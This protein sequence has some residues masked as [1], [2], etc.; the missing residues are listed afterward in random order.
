MSGTSWLDDYW[1]ERQK[2]QER[3]E[4]QKR[5]RLQRGN[6]PRTVR[7]AITA[8]AYGYTPRNRWNQPRPV[9]TE[10]HSI[11]DDDAD[12][13]AAVVRVL[14]S[15]AT[16]IAWCDNGGDVYVSDR[17]Y[18][19]TTSQHLAKLT[20]ELVCAG[21]VMVR[22]DARLA[23]SGV[24]GGYLRRDITPFQHWK[25]RAL[26]TRGDEW[27][28]YPNDASAAILGGAWVSPNGIWSIVR[29]RHAIGAYDLPYTVLRNGRATMARI[30]RDGL[31]VT[32]YAGDLPAYVR[33]ALADLF[34][35]TP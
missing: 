25:L 2:R 20:N 32:P 10:Y 17:R 18:S 8:F 30:L 23:P 26:A 5:E 34:T 7:E 28:E 27:D 14:H 29:N 1:Q 9:W 3:Q 22:R 12:N 19:A 13:A 11:A 31:V 21:Y 33:R 16:P 4:R 24:Y 15:Y 35:D 6:K